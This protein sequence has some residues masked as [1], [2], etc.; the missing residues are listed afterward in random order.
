MATFTVRVELH[1]ATSKDYDK[2]HNE[3][4]REGFSRTVTADS[5]TEYW[6]PSAEY[7]R[8]GNL[9]RDEVRDSAD[10]A[11]KKT[12]K[13]HAVLVTESEGRCWRGLKKVDAS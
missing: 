5:G 12:G 2:L 11:A 9:T 10:R 1:D 6:L 13:K 3:M 8:T 7:D 4:E